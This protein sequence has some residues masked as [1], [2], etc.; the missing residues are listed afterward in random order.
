MLLLEQRAQQG[1]PGLH[2][3]ARRQAL[4]GR[5][6]PPKLPAGRARRAAARAQPYTCT[7]GLE[8][9]TFVLLMGRADAALLSRR[10][11]GRPAQR[12]KSVQGHQDMLAENHGSD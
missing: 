10:P 12:D 3:G 8:Q 7:S 9:N 6:A 5:P 1:A 11:E 4:Q 2:A